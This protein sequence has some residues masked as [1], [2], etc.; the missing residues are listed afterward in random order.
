[1]RRTL[2]LMALA[3]L[4]ACN[5]PAE[6]AVSTSSAASAPTSSPAASTSTAS[7]PEAQ[8]SAAASEPAAGDLWSAAKPAEVQAW[9]EAAGTEPQTDAPTVQAATLSYPAETQTVAYAT[10]RSD[11]PAEVTLLNLTA[12][13]SAR[14]LPAGEP[15]AERWLA[16]GAVNSRCPSP[17]LR[18]LV[19]TGEV[20]PRDGREWSGALGLLPDPEP[21]SGV[22][23]TV[24]DLRQTL[25]GEPL[26]LNEWNVVQQATLGSGE[27]AFMQAVAVYPTDAALPVPAG[28]AADE[29][30]WLEGE[31]GAP[32]T[33]GELSLPALPAAD[34]TP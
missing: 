23:G 30:V 24:D 25:R 17:E 8:A 32:L 16:G 11:R 27:S 12:E 26:R 5:P 18:V 19:M 1:M 14:S 33:Y 34:A 22:S 3:L 6:D 9:V 15:Y 10:I 21:C 20:P 7:A 4:T 28:A 31:A 29:L 2:P 13:R